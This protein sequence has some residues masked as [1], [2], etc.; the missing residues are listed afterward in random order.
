MISC[1]ECGCVHDRGR[2]L[3]D[4]RRLFGLLRAAFHQWSASHEFQPTNEAQLRA[5][6]LVQTGH[7]N[8]AKAEVPPGYQESEA[9]RSQYRETVAGICRAVVGEGAYFELRTGTDAVEIVTARS[10][11]FAT[12]GRREFNGI[13]EAVELFLEDALGVTADQ[14][15]RERAA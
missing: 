13:R 1:P 14:L 11:D 6:A 12:V 7:T 10:I 4:H 3:P 2:S 9:I 5:W 8:V 15:L